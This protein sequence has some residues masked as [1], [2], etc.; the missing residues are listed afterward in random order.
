MARD[1]TRKT[2]DDAELTETFAIPLARA[3]QV[4]RQKQRQRGWKLY[5]LHAPEVECIGQGKSAGNL[6]VRLQ[7]LPG[8][9]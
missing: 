5:S 9:A 2:E 7:G 1:I 4:R 6:R 8:H 3:D